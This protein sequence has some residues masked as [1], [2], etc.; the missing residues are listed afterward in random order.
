MPIKWCVALTLITWR[1]AALYFRGWPSRDE[2][3]R[4]L[5]PPGFLT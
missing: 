3:W 1:V 5:S 4:W 2:W